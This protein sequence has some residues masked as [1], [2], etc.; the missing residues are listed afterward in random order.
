MCVIQLYTIVT[1]NMIL[2]SSD[3][4]PSHPQDNYHSTDIV[5]RM[6]ENYQRITQTKQKEENTGKPK[7]PLF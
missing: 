7:P 2:N 3:N 4:I 5:S 6:G 1:H